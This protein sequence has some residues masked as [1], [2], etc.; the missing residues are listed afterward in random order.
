VARRS[1]APLARAAAAVAALLALAGCSS[2]GPG[3]PSPSPQRSVT[4]PASD[5]SPSSAAPS[6]R[7]GPAAGLGQ[8]GRFRTAKYKIWFTEPAHT[9]PAGEH[10]GPRKLLTVIRYP[11]AGGPAGRRRPA[12]GPLP[13]IVFG[14]GFQQCDAPYADLLRAWASAGYVVAAVNFPE[15]D[16][17]TGSAAT[18]SD[19]VNQPGDMSYVITRMLALSA[20]KHGLFAG[21]LS[22]REIAVSGQSDGGD[23]VAA[24][25]ANSCCTDRRV[26]ADAVLSGAEWPPMPGR[27]FTRRPPPMLFTQ[28]SADTINDP[29]CSVAMYHADPARDRFYLD[30]LGAD[31]LLPYWG[32]DRYERITAR[33]TVAFFDRFVLGQRPAGPAMRRHGD[34]PGL[35]ELFSHGGGGLPAGPCAT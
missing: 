27:F 19:M 15:S 5:P 21:S 8:I 26:A 25:G 28:G 13:L 18:E 20:A 14:P 31:H 11:L 3:G 33:V 9:G 4:R 7:T 32:N 6:R 22:R 35:A 24:V 34:V 10:L 16:C 2:S 12:R 1:P 30:L 17:L 29:G 23:T